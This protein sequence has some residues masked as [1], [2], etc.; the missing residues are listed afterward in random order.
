[1]LAVQG[2]YDGAVFKPLEKITAKPNQRV[3]ITIWTNLWSLLMSLVKRGCAA[4]LRN[5][6]ILR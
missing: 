1:M 4:L 6:P 5:T 2:Y 3:I